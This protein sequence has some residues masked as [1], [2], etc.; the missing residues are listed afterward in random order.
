MEAKQF[1]IVQ[2]HPKHEGW[3]PVPTAF[4]ESKISKP[5]AAPKTCL[6]LKSL[7]SKFVHVLWDPRPAL[8]AGIHSKLTGGIGQ[9]HSLEL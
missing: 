7:S 5:A 1:T 3:K 4:N 8:C 9:L 2:G 6:K